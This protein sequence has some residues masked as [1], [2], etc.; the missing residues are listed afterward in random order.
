MGAKMGNF[1]QIRGMNMA[2]I[3]LRLALLGVFA[4]LTLAAQAQE[5]PVPAAAPQVIS[6][7]SVLLR[8]G[9]DSVLKATE[10]TGPAEFPNLYRVP[11]FYEKKELDRLRTLERQGD[12]PQLDKYLTAYIEKFGI[13][14]FTRDN[15]LLWL[16][17]RV[18]QVQEDTSRALFYYE[19]AALH[20]NTGEIP[21]LAFDSLRSY[22]ESEWLPVD[23]YYELIEYRRRI[24]PFLPS[25]KFLSSMGPAIN[26][27]SADYAPFMHPTDSVLIFT[28]RRD[29]SGT[30]P[31]DI[32]DPFEKPNED[33]FYSVKDFITGKWEN[34][35]RMPKTINSLLNEGSACLAPDGKTLFFTRCNDP[36]GY[37]DC[38]IFQ[39][40]YDPAA[41][42]WTEI[43]NLGS[44]VNSNYWDSQ[45]NIS[46]DGTTL[47]FSSN[48]KGGFGGSDL[49][50]CTLK[51]S[52]LWGEPRNIGPVINTARDEV[53]PFFH[54]INS[55]LYFSSSGHMQNFGSFDIFKSR[56]MG[57]GWE[58]VK[59]VGP[60]VNT[61]GN[62]YYF[63]IDSDGET[64]FYS[65]SRNPEEDH[66]RQDFDL[67]SFPMPMEA[68][69]DAVASLSG[70]LL[71]SISGNPLTGNIMIIDLDN[72]IEVAPKRINGRGY[73]EFD[74]KD[75]NRYQIIV[76]GNNF[77]TINQELVMNGDTTFNILAKSLEEGKPLVFESM[78]FG[79]NSDK[80]KMRSKPNLDYLVGFLKQYPMF[81]LVIEGHTDSDGNPK[82]NLDLSRRRAQAI[83]NYIEYN[84][85]FSAERIKFFGYG[86][87]RPLVPND[88][89]ENKR[90]NRR[91][92]FRL[93]WDPTYKG[94]APLPSWQELRFQ[95]KKTD[96]ELDDDL[97]L[98]ENFGK[99]FEEP[100]D[101]ELDLD[102]E[103]KQMEVPKPVKP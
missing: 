11:Y 58:L 9:I 22:T 76:M 96:I 88:S 94:D 54:S 103:L 24:N 32:L 23:K 28:S 53:T 57:D 7:K 98:P 35:R 13:E 92:E 21:I 63:S 95:K 83:A 51:S 56:W 82:Y 69:P 42:S 71:D 3:Q 18:K 2:G 30:N 36:A 1:Q 33:L 10:V 72:G 102:A 19:L 60:L 67:F 101:D 100:M 47:F 20:N 59:N 8:T 61:D 27:A 46:A 14:N 45:P 81:R 62:Q 26:S 48:R 87:T 97:A 41:D 99:E 16:A 91:V 40:T 93:E 39:A 37:G 29:T 52:G 25:R 64:I 5:E 75:N 38:D 49:Y 43:R 80:L 90:Q 79:S 15:N 70:V 6:Q 68:R 65:N 34:A 84:G 31:K 89:E 77:L 74:L 12:L 78:E 66:I 50:F 55:T 73:F 86:D 4:A 44:K 17:G 85:Q